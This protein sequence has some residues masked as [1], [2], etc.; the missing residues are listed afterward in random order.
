MNL[1]EQIERIKSMM[2]ID[3]SDNI[4]FL[5]RRI[6]LIPKY[7][8]GSYDWLNPGA[9]YTIDEFIDRVVFSATREFISDNRDDLE[10]EHQLD[11]RDEI[12][13]M[14]KKYLINDKEL[15]E[16]VVKYFNS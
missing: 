10:Y 6:D 3:E 7:I 13:P 2:R 14:I 4:L 16:E 8:R 12:E 15:Y 9:F 5:K 1:N 11:V